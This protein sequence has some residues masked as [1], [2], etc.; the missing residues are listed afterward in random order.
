[1]V[2]AVY[3]V[4][5]FFFSIKAGV[6]YALR[7]AQRRKTEWRSWPGRIPRDRT[8]QGFPCLQA[9][10]LLYHLNLGTN[11]ISLLIG[12][13]WG[14]RLAS[15]FSASQVHPHSRLPRSHCQECSWHRWN[16]TQLFSQMQKWTSCVSI[17]IDI[18]KNK[19]H[20][21]YVI[22]SVPIQLYFPQ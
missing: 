12:Q 11:K 22:L 3:F 20:T 19:R 1:M 8:G 2:S 13:A 10:T 15:V 6:S 4:L 7:E 17:W 18:F 14:S 21:H 16:T 5:P 9:F